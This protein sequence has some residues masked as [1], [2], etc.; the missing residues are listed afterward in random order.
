[1]NGLINVNGQGLDD[2]AVVLWLAAFYQDRKAANLTQ[3]TIQFYAEKIRYFVDYCNDR[4]VIRVGDI[5]PVT[6][7]GFL[8]WLG[9]SHNPGGVH[10]CYRTVRAFLRWYEQ[11]RDLPGWK[12][13]ISRVK[14]PR[15]AI[16][17]IA[18]VELSDVEKLIT[19]CEGDSFT[20]RR[21]RAIILTLLDSGAR[22][23]EILACKLS[24]Y[25]AVTGEIL[26]E[27]GKSQKPRVVYAGKRTRRAIRTYL[28]ARADHCQF[29][30][31]TDEGQPMK[32]DGLRGILTRRAKSAGLAETP[33]P[34]DFRRAFALNFLRNG[35]D[36]MT[37]QKLLG[38]NSLAVLR[39]YLAQTD[40]DT[41][42]GHAQFSPVDHM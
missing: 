40:R 10:A 19:A 39:R 31:V 23:A 30:W 25:N 12:N 20:A 24:D 21:D 41:A 6:L 38:H 29:M 26:I 33:S 5:T 28:R 2:D 4:G 36:V 16:E 37:L 7:R 22:V 3:R 8:L 27:R 13:P 9:E 42:T 34:H 11:E 18:G 32:Y 35:G 1:M 15:V 17:P 14:P